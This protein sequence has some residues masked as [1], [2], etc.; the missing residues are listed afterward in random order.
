M[1]EWLRGSVAAIGNGP[2][3]VHSDVLRAGRPFVMYEGRHA[4]LDAHVELLAAAG[5]PLWMPTFHYGFTRDG[6]FDVRESPSEV[7][8]LTERFRSA[9]AAWRTPVPVFSFAGSGAAPDV[10]TR[11]LIDPFDERS[12]FA[13]MVRDDAVLLFYGAPFS[14]STIKHHVERCA[15]GPLYRF[16]KDFAGEVRDVSGV[17][18]PVVLR[19][20]VRPLGLHL[21]YDDDRIER[22][23]EADVGAVGVRRFDR[24]GARLLALSARR[25]V[26]AWS[27]RLASDP[28]SFLDAPSRRWVEPA[29]QEL[30]RRFERADFEGPEPIAVAAG[31]RGVD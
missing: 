1:L 31:R 14:S 25:A 21:S 20:H 6:R 24:A 8:A 28:L 9:S 27:G 3:V 15:G 16:D 23:L 7:G 19:Y 22:E 12:A 13:A 29:L 5:R 30:G 4:W 2:M 26:D 11:Q 18:R 10:N 17:A